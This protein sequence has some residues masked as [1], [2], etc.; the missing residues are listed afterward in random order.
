MSQV[1]TVSER[2]LP[3]YL[4][5]WQV[6]CYLNYSRCKRE[7]RNACILAPNIWDSTLSKMAYEMV[8][9]LLTY[10]PRGDCLAVLSIRWCTF[11]LWPTKS[12]SSWQLHH[13][14]KC[15]LIPLTVAC[16]PLLVIWTQWAEWESHARIFRALGNHSYHLHEPIDRNLWMENV[17][18]KPFLPL[19]W[20]TIGPWITW[21]DHPP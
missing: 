16:R 5:T 9:A 12:L 2:N 21:L 3:K 17:S 14:A 10:V 11:H 6:Q 4:R 1:N 18:L 15:H 20:L 7:T 13:S 8:L 19:A